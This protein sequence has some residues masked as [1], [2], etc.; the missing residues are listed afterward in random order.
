MPYSVIACRNKIL[1]NYDVIVVVTF[2]VL[3][4]YVMFLKDID[5]FVSR[6]FNGAV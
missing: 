3:S 6:E 5:I 1:Q 4:D 2:E